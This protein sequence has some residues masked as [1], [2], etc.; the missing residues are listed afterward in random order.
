MA[1]IKHVTVNRYNF[2][3]IL[4]ADFDKVLSVYRS[5]EIYVDSSEELLRRFAQYPIPESY[6]F[7]DTISIGNDRRAIIF[8]GKYSKWSA[9][10]L[11]ERIID[12]Y[13]PVK[14]KI[15]YYSK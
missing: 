14:Y 13:W 10:R 2:H 6:E 9:I 15:T 11:I 7:Y 1:G 4:P 12:I 5:G 3:A 8:K